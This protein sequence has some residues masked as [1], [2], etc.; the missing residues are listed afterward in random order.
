MKWSIEQGGSYN[1][2]VDGLLIVLLIL[3]IAALLMPNRLLFMLGGIWTSYFF[4]HKYYEKKLQHSLIVEND[5]KKVRLFPGQESKIVFSLKNNS[6]FPFV[7]GEFRFKHGHAIRTDASKQNEVVF[8]ATI[9]GKRNA[10]IEIPLVAERRGTTRIFGLSYTFPHLF[11]FD[12]TRLI[13]R[14]I[15]Q[16]EY[17][18]FPRLLPVEG[19]NEVMNIVSGEQRVRTSPFEDIQSPVGIRDY[20]MSDPFY[21]I[22]WKASAKTRTLQTNVYEKVNDLSLAF[23]VN[24]SGT[25]P[26][27]FNQ[28]HENLL[29]YTAYLCQQANENGYTYEI[30]IN[31]RMHGNA[32]YLHIPEGNGT[33]HYLQAL[34]MLANVNP[35]SS[36]LPFEPFI[37]R[38]GQQFT[39]P[40]IIIFIGNTSPQFQTVTAK[41]KYRQHAMFFVEDR[42]ESAVIQ[43]MGKE[44]KRYG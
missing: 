20:S 10:R 30:F 15:F 27:S 3:F 38:V 43:P 32:P 25:N 5:R 23:V 33:T 18:V 22:N 2:H 29:S 24:L 31:L 40:K 44:A 34:E 1:K 17:I 14:T 26:T 9:L 36:Q 19:L 8:P 11:L 4:I 21:R 39:K 16:T 28:N 42:G 35:L 41:W 6:F 12:K 7:N 37:Y 13:N